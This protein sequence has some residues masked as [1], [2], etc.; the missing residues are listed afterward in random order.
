MSDTDVAFQQA[1]EKY[2]TWIREIASSEEP[3]YTERL[4]EYLLSN[5]F[6]AVELF[7]ETQRLLGIHPEFL[8]EHTNGAL[9]ATTDFVKENVL[10]YNTYEESQGEQDD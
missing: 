2:L 10:D 3:G 8:G 5:T 6:I 4:E 7:N 9:R 1:K